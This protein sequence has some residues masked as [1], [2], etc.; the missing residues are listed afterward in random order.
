MLQ[1]EVAMAL[2][3]LRA[4]ALTEG[5]GTF[6]LV[7]VIMLSPHAGAMAA[8]AVGVGLMAFIY[9]G[10]HISGAHY[11]PAVSLVMWRQRVID[12]K[13]FWSFVLVQCGAA[14]AGALVGS[15][16]M[17]MV[18]S[19]ADAVPVRAASADTLIRML[20]AEALFTWMMVL[21]ILNVA[22][23]PRTAGNQY[24]GVAIGFAVAAGAMVAGPIS[25]AAFNPAVGLALVVSGRVPN[26]LQPEYIAMVY[27]LAPVAGALAAW[28]TY[29]AQR[30]WEASQA[31]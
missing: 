8:I 17:P 13:T 30:A 19:V 23:H 22:T 12:V 26:G 27:V 7:L 1:A 24:Y 9:M 18:A 6:F 5:V 3:S 4:K 20:A 29:R 2:S 10:G 28:G 16:L 15:G 31:A 14:V 25:G 11:N 21:V